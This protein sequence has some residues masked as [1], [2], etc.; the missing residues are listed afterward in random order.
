LSW[1][2]SP[3]LSA[4]CDL[5]SITP[6]TDAHDTRRIGHASGIEHIPTETAW[7]AK[8][9]FETMEVGR[10]QSPSIGADVARGHT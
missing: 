9:S 2:I 10:F 1:C 7:A 8:E 3:N 4:E 5:D 6:D